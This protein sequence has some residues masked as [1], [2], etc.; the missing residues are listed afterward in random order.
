MSV[1]DGLIGMRNKGHGEE[2]TRRADCTM[3]FV[4]HPQLLGKEFKD[5][6]TEPT[7]QPARRR[8]PGYPMKGEQDDQGR[9]DGF[10]ID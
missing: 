8:A 6:H 7:T 4:K 10:R 2:S 9:A 3:H 1:T 5:W